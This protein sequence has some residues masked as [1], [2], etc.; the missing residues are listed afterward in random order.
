MNCPRC[1]TPIGRLPDPDSIVTCP[2]CGSRL[3]TRAA[4]RR[5]QGGP[6]GAATTGTKPPLPSAPAPR[7][8]TTPAPARAKVELSDPD[9]RAFDNAAEL[10]PSATVPPTPA[11]VF[12]IKRPRHAGPPSP[13]EA[14]QR[15][16]EEVRVLRSVQERILELLLQRNPGALA[17]ATPDAAGGPDNSGLAAIRA[18][19]RK[20][21]VLIDD[22]SVTREAAVAELLQADVPVRAFD[23]GNAALSG[24]AADRPDVIV[25]E[26]GLDGDMAGKDVINMIKA[27]MEWVDIPLVLWTREPVANQKEARQILGADEI[28]PKS[29]GA[30]ALVARIISIFRRP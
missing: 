27:T 29:G 28:V 4:A 13:G 21:V 9:L 15:L 20:S 23:D 1:Q 7:A 24:I 16:L 11:E 10:P 19:H 8:G 2:G 12:G 14:Y 30:A 25:L 26:L 22:D 6:K 18:R 5:S 17:T 3:M